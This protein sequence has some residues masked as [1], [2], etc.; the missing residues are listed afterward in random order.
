MG[1]LRII[2]AVLLAAAAVGLSGKAAAQSKQDIN[3]QLRKFI[4][5]YTSLNDSYIYPVDNAELIEQAIEDI[6]AELDPHSAYMSAEEMV[7]VSESFEGKFSGIGIQINMQADTLRV[8]GV[9]AGGPSEKVGLHPGDRILSADGT[10]LVGMLQTDAIKRLRGP[11]GSTIDIE[12][13]RPGESEQLSFRIVRDDISIE[14]IDAA[15]MPAPK[16]GYIRVNR[17]A[18]T[19]M[20]EMKAAF[21]KFDNPEALILD[22]RGNG[23]GLLTQAIEMSNFFLPRGSLIVSTKGRK[24][25]DME[26]LAPHEGTFRKGRVVVLIDE[27]SAS[28]SEIVAGALQDWDRAVVV[29]RRSYGKGLVQRQF[30]LADGSA[31]NITVSKYLTP[32]G[33]PIQRPFENG[34]ASDYRDSFVERFRDGY[35]DTL[36]RADSLRYPTLRL[37]KDVYSD[38]GIYPDYY[39]HADTTGYTSYLGALIRKGVIY[40]YTNRYLDTN[41]DHLLELYPTLKL[42]RYTFAMSP[43]MLD[44]LTALG[45]Q[46]D[47]P[48][49]ESDLLESRRLIEKRFKIYVA[50]S[51]WGESASYELANADDPVMLEAMKVLSNWETMADG[52]AAGE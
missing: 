24:V 2:I 22:L 43:E 39:V 20:D 37:K 51:L 7:G 8:A 42:L 41:R 9:I 4:Q 50:R 31:V 16:T 10:S 46:R 36:N 35:I 25:P 52:I 33:R 23:G 11:K 49:T 5:F 3:L 47:V 29:G 1:K 12:V 17:F 26:Y 15:Y 6:L 45:A 21:A 48:V 32:S 19:T 18:H 38:G 27:F 14:T 44:E 40:E 34:N 30:P 13:A 28:A